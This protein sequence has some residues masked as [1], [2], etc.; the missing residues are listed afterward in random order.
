MT[1]LDE[2][3]LA[4]AMRSTGHSIRKIATELN[5]S[6][7]SVSLWVRGIHLTDAQKQ[8]LLKNQDGNLMK[9]NTKMQL[10][11]LKTREEF[12]QKGYDLAEADEQF[13]LICA[14]YW[15]E[16]SKSSCGIYFTNSDVAMMKLFVK[17]IKE[18]LCVLPSDIKLWCQCHGESSVESNRLFW[19]T[20][21][22][23][24]MSSWKKPTVLNPN[25]KNRSNKLQ[26]G[27]CRIHVYDVKKFEMIL[28]GID[29]LKSL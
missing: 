1:K 26:Y 7:S 21:L 3:T 2:K 28:G 11:W 12:R 9:G 5:V 27:I 24:P 10:R 25:N 19:T 18:K 13:R 16:G 8:T 14:L 23:L 29:Y 6:K 17:T 20:I 22:E 15:A 4:R